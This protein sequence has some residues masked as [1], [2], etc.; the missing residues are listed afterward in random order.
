MLRTVFITGFLSWISLLHAQDII[1]K[2]NSEE[3]QAK[4]TTVLPVQTVSLVNAKKGDIVTINGQQAIVFQTYGDGHGKAMCVKALRGKKNAW[5]SSKAINRFRTTDKENGRTN[6][7]AV[8]RF[9]EENN[10]NIND[11]PAISWCKQLGE[12]WYIPS[13]KELEAFV[14]WW[15]GNDM[16][17]DW[18]DESDDDT[19]SPTV[20]ETPFSKQINKQLLEAGG[21]PFING[22][23][24]STENA[25]GKLSVFWYNERKG[26]WQFSTV[27]KTS[28]GTMYLGRAFF[29]Y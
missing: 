2:T 29:A 26:Y 5:G 20:S 4:V 9:V 18:D 12:G 1:T 13:I 21:I 3:I 8:F 11:F 24:T 16:E 6:T 27:S 28:V 14:N 25:K 10:L 19:Q 17:L 15:L 22:A 23:F 7:E